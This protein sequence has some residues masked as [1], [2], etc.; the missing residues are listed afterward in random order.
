ML[1]YLGGILILIAGY[2]F[3]GNFVTKIF[4][5]EK[6]KETPAH[7]KS[8]GV[9]YIAMSWPRAFLIQ[10]L[11]I[12]G[13]GPIYGAVMGALFGP[14]AFL[15][16]VLGCIF[17]GTVHDYLIGMISVRDD[18]ATVAE[19]VGDYL[20]EGARKFMR[21]FSILV[22]ILVGTVFMTGPAK[23][24]ASMTGLSL[25]AWL[26]LIISYYFLATILPVDKIIAKFY[27]LLGGA[28]LIMA[29]G[30]GGGLII[31]DY[32]IPNLTLANLHPKSLSLWPFLFVT[33]A[34]G[35]I[36]GFHA[37]QSPLM[38]R[39]LDN[40][41]DGKKVF[42][43][44]MIAE[45]II[46]IIWAAASMT[47]FGDTVGLSEALNSLGGAGGVV[48]EISDSML[49][50]T[51]GIMAMLGVIALPISSGDTAFRSVRLALADMLKLDQKDKTNRFK[52]A[53]PIFMIGIILSQVDFSI[54]WRYFAWSNQ[55][56]AMMA[57][58]AGAAYLA[59]QDKLHWI[60]TIPATFMTAVS[61][62]YIFA[63]PEGFQL[64][65]AIATPIG[66]ITAGGA[67][68]LFLTKGQDATVEKKKSV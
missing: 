35:A 51:G 19:I 54:I 40:E 62:S 17:A 18:G 22:L 36:S 32:N 16:I 46:A 10:L 42:Y 67:L 29:L 37:T 39:C 43:G 4:G 23:L 58:W 60:A 65:L 63:A 9:D 53:I 55:T 57:L 12:A 28:L 1:S 66:I 47:F 50:V 68:T 38:A 33:I 27:P 13:L 25:N 31:G 2:I 5:A 15:W 20:G 56:L 26:V 34:C 3:Y 41:D 7:T 30:V 6:T 21:V 52:I 14:A 48:K 64:S 24:L 8:D 61:I 45:G 44:A 49:G 11:N 59:Q